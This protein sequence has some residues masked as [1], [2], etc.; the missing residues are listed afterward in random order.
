M[1]RPPVEYKF[2]TQPPKRATQNLLHPTR[3]AQ[4]PGLSDPYAW[5]NKSNPVTTS[6]DQLRPFYTTAL[7]SVNEHVSVNNHVHRPY[8]FIHRPY[9]FILSDVYLTQVTNPDI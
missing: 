2:A 3:E 1:T 9:Q 5:G 4:S 8:K 7:S 6:Y